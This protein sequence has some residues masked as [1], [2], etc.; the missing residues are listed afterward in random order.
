MNRFPCCGGSDE[1][2]QEHTQDCAATAEWL[3][4]QWMKEQDF[5]EEEC[6]RRDAEIERL[7]A[8]L[9]ASATQRT[10][11]ME[12]RG[13]LL[14]QIVDLKAELARLT[15]SGQVAEEYEAIRKTLVA[16]GVFSQDS[17][18]DA[19]FSLA[20]KAQ[21]YE[22]ARAALKETAERLGTIACA[23]CDWRDRH[24]GTLA[25]SKAKLVFHVAMCVKHPLRALE[26]ERDALQAEKDSLTLAY[27][28]ACSGRDNARTSEA[29]WRKRLEAAAEVLG[30]VLPGECGPLAIVTRVKALKEE[31]EAS[32]AYESHLKTTIDS[33]RAERAAA[34]ADNAALGV[35]VNEQASVE[36][37]DVQDDLCGTCGP[38]LARALVSQSHPGAALLKEMQEQAETLTMA[39][40]V[41]ELYGEQAAKTRVVILNEEGLGILQALVKRLRKVIK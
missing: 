30:D 14:K 40:H 9:A 33:L 5:R 38:C 39:L 15:P 27:T 32:R 24:D 25:D 1:T 10:R 19:L 20:A 37:E 11:E 16:H 21:G 23:Y 29:A 26:A 36:C 35:F 31:R 34:V 8:E 17:P 4:Q 28:D 13:G 12:A 22:A 2:P 18:H 41:L 6:R 7:K 3:R